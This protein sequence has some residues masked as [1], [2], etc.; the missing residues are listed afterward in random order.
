VRGDI[1]GLDNCGR[2]LGPIRPP[3]P[4]TVAAAFFGEDLSPGRL[5]PEAIWESQQSRAGGIPKRIGIAHITAQRVDRLV[6]AHVHRRRVSIPFACEPTH[7]FELNAWDRAPTPGGA[8]PINVDRAALR[9][10][11]DSQH[12]T[13]ILRDPAHCARL[14]LCWGLGGKRARGEPGNQVTH[15]STSSDV[16]Y[17]VE[18]GGVRR[19]RTR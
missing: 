2:L 1:R 12:G 16:H 4:T 10:G 15:P 13:E 7:S 9:F 5:C 11:A 17:G 14:G 8:A 18:F 3:S 19:C 6:P